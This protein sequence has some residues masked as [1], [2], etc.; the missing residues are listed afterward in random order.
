MTNSRRHNSINLADNTTAHSRRSLPGDK[1]VII[2][3]FGWSWDSVAAECKAFI[4][5]AGYG[6]VQVSP[7]TEHIIGEQWWTDYQPVSYEISS[8]RGNREQFANMV[9]ACHS[10]GVGVIAD[11]VIN[12][13]SAMAGGI[14]LAGSE[15][16]RYQ[17]GA[18]YQPQD[19]HD[20]LR[21]GDNEINDYSDRFE[22]QNCMLGGLADI[23]TE[24]EYPR[25]RLAEYLEDL[26]SLGVDG[27]R[28]DAAKHIPAADLKNILSRLSRQVYIT[29]EVIYGAGEAVQPEEY[30]GNGQFR[31][32]YALRDAFLGGNIAQLADINNRGWIDGLH[33]NVFVANHDTERIF[34]DLS[35]SSPANTFT[36]ATVFSLAYPYGAPTVVSSYSFDNKDS[37]A[38]NQGDGYCDVAKGYTNGGSGGWLCQHRWTAIA[39]MVAFRKAVGSEELSNWQS[40]ESSKIAFGRGSKGFVV[41]NNADSEWSS[42]FETSLPDGNYCNMLSEACA[43]SVTVSG[44]KFWTTVSGRS[45]FAIHTE[46]RF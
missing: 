29:Q 25:K 34:G 31:Y 36:L 15:F 6:F 32:L 38:P 1:A 10:V 42:S 19:F 41:I 5:P 4:G 9:N 22:V 45:A 11:A 37:G 40:P 26:L 20:C 12:H 3:M 13:M 2:Q 21:H 24:A 39:G 7:A 23:K 33:A 14:G 18:I 43:T 28:I 8:K 27:L 30:L 46:G 35:Y 17:Y 16:S 44:G